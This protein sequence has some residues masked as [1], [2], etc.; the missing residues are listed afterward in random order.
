VEAFSEKLKKGDSACKAVWE[1]YLTFLCMGINNTRTILDC[2]IILG[3]TL[4]RYAGDYFDEIKF[5]LAKINAFDNN[6]DYLHLSN[7]TSNASAIG[8]A[9]HFVD[10]FIK[11]V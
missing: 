8:T 5:R 7:Y 9:L 6:A 2:E 4:A 1:E 3:G 10:E 11:K